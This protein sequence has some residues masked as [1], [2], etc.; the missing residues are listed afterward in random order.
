MFQ[1]KLPLTNIDTD[2]V[3]GMAGFIT[4]KGDL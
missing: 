2:L 4:A 1:P 3:N